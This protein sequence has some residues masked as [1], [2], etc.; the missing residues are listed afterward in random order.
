[1]LRLS[2]DGVSD[3]DIAVRFRRSPDF[4]RR[5]LDLARLPGR[6][7]PD[8]I[9]MGAGVHSLRPLERCVLG[10]RERGA[11][12]AEIAPRFRRSE[13]FTEQVETLARYKLTVDSE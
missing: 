13:T 7:M 3:D 11:S 12:H 4:V 2:G 9:P 8:A 6:H 10:W 5:V 1:M